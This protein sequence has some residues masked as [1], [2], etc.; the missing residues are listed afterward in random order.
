M[1]FLHVPVGEEGEAINNV[2]RWP[3]RSAVVLLAGA[4][5][6]VFGTA[7]VSDAGMAPTR[8]LA[9]ISGVAP[10]MDGRLDSLTRMMTPA[11]I[12]A[13]LYGVFCTSP[14]SCWAVGHHYGN[15][16]ATLNQMIRWNG[17]KW[18]PYPVPEP[19]GT[20]V[21]DYNALVSVR[22]LNSGD[23]WAVGSDSK[24]AGTGNQVLHWNGTK[25]SHSSAPTP[26]P[27]HSGDENQLDDI[28]CV[29]PADCWVVGYFG[30]LG[31][32]TFA[33]QAMRWNGKKWSLVTT[34]D[35]AGRATG[36]Q[37]ELNAIRCT[38]AAACV[39]DGYDGH[40]SSFSNEVLRWNGKKWSMQT[41]PNPGGTAT[42]DANLLNGLACSSPTSCWAA[43]EDG[44]ENPATWVNEMLHW[45]GKKWLTTKVPDPATGTGAVNDLL[46]DTCLSATNCWAVGYHGHESATT[47]VFRND[48]LHW[49]GIKWSHV[50]SPDPGGTTTSGFNG[51]AGIRCTSAANCWAVGIRVKNNHIADE[52][53]HW[54]GTK[55]TSVDIA[56]G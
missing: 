11:D 19:G 35:P 34:P 16:T 32:H 15:G 33:N 43:G 54:N 38:A 4:L 46:W 23:C 3:A 53:L 37:N 2:M 42:G 1:V 44:P 20:A 17:S 6:A 45:N 9:A 10:P 52:I 50:S 28:T 48:T 22:C 26:G 55:W 40:T 7:A 29:S 5:I 49:N 13:E 30:S 36:D 18:R 25:W 41:T 21:D 31:S 8:V 14:G 56:A 47:T 51:L 39:A 12:F 27:T 24:G